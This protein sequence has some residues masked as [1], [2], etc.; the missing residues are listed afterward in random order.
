MSVV[1][2]LL[3]AVFAAFWLLEAVCHFV[4]KNAVGSETISHLSRR[5]A[6]KLTGR[7]WHL[8]MFV[9]PLLLFLD[10]EGLL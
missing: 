4:L 9:P 7:Y 6:Q 1:E 3:F 8:V 10:L 2:Y 5:L